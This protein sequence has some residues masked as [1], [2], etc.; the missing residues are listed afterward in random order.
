MMFRD[1]C[2]DS[3]LVI[4]GEQEAN[5]QVRVRPR[6]CM[7]GAA[8]LH[9]SEQRHPHSQTLG[10]CPSWEWVPGG[11]VVTLQGSV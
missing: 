3:L 9:Q 1:F 6:Q 10:H 11:L 2:Q 5:L 8:V 7:D 4:P